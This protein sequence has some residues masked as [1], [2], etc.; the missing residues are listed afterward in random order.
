[1]NLYKYESTDNTTYNIHP[2][3]DSEKK[4]VFTQNLSKKIQSLA[5][6][7][8]SYTQGLH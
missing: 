5:C 7:K 2:K 8:E 3:N 6:P 1:M 4:K